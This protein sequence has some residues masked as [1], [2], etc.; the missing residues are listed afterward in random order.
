M[1]KPKTSANSNIPEGFKV[2]I[3]LP[4]AVIHVLTASEPQIIR[5][6]QDRIISAHL[7]IIPNTEHGDS[8]GFID[9]SAVIAVSWRQTNV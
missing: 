8:I 3:F 5:D 6:E 4:G 2:R 1:S 7:D 9:W